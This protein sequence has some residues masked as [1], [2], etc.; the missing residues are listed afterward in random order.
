MRIV[1]EMLKQKTSQEAVSFSGL[2]SRELFFHLINSDEFPEIRLVAQTLLENT[3][4]KI[5]AHFFSQNAPLFLQP[6]TYSLDNFQERLQKIDSTSLIH[7]DWEK[8]DQKK[9][10][11]FVYQ[12]TPSALTTGSWIQSVSNAATCHS[13]MAAK[14]FQTYSHFL[15][16]GQA[17]HHISNIYQSLLH[18]HG[19]TIPDVLSYSFITQAEIL[20]SAFSGPVFGLA[21]SLFPQK[22]LPEILGFHLAHFFLRSDNSYL[23]LEKCLNTSFEMKLLRERTLSSCHKKIAEETI[24]LYLEKIKQEH[25]S[26]EQEEKWQRIWQGFVL[27]YF[28]H[29]NLMR[30]LTESIESDRKQQS[31][32]EKM[33][34]MLHKK[35]PYSRG[36][37]KSAYV[38]QKTVND[39]FMDENFDPAHF[40]QT[41]ARSPLVD[42]ENPDE[43]LFFRN[44]LSFGGPMFRVF[45]EEETETIREWMRGI[46]ETLGKT[47]EISETPAQVACPRESI[48]K[49]NSL[50][51]ASHQKE[52]AIRKY[53]PRELFYFL[54]N[55]EKYPEV[56][57]AAKEYAQKCIELALRETKKKNL[58][59]EKQFFSYT[60]QAFEERILAIYEK[61]TSGYQSFSAPPKISREGYIWGICQF[62]PFVL[63]DGCWLQNIAKT[64]TSQQE[65]SAR[66]FK[67]YADEIG[68]GETSY[69]HPNVY[70]KLLNSIKRPMPPTHSWEFSQQK[71]ILEAA[72][73]FPN[74]LLS[75]SFFPR[76]FLP[77]LLGI[78]L[79]IELSGLGK[80]YMKL[81]DEL[82]YWNIDPYIISLHISIDNMASGHSYLAMESIQIYLD[83]LLATGGQSEAQKQ[84]QRIWAGYL[85]F[86]TS[87]RRFFIS[88]A[89]KYGVKFWLPLK[90]GLKH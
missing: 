53:K 77:E 72:F 80:D 64:G 75:L 60:H 15:G 40:L 31:P 83:H 21:L 86:E 13:E 90:L 7:F 51:P 47:P 8:I 26:Q 25:S 5:N 87:Q 1:T 46:P 89:M 30:D 84:W 73:D 57:P 20:D 42:P 37:H 32:S 38:G 59:P 4:Q 68:N 18:E 66:L 27:F 49:K 12:L 62:A 61:E 63:V 14:L 52:E 36:V 24:S 65:L 85:A 3:F 33:V 69:N 39:W 67:I 16:D 28:V 79:A 74:L 82:N 54:M 19:I 23:D 71:E 45:T 78:N 2:N 9:Q 88:L 34:A 41:L 44:L 76:T 35:A 81:V 58:A 29:Q 48:R 6:F 11:H 55:Q 43:S 17:A 56:R 10:R 70:R 22:F 50:Y